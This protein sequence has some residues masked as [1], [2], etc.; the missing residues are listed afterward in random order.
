MKSCLSTLLI[1]LKVTVNYNKISQKIKDNNKVVFLF[2]G[3][4]G[5]WA[6][7]GD[8]AW[9]TIWDATVHLRLV[10][11]RPLPYCSTL[12]RQPPNGLLC[13]LEITKAE[14]YQLTIKIT[15]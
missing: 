8:L 5:V 11:T 7:P 6:T 14:N 12:P 1:K 10:P 15:D 2:L 4:G 3:V 13:G 9:G